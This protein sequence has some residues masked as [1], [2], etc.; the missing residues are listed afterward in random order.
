MKKSVRDIL[1]ALVVCFVTFVLTVF[2]LISPLDYILK[3]ALYQIPRGISG[4]IKIIGID[5]KTLE[6]LGPINTTAI[7]WKFLIP[8]RMPDRL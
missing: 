6:E 4:N 2:N 7:L 5:E 3:D 1:E 8:I